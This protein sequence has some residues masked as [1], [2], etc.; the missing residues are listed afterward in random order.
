MRLYNPGN[1]LSQYKPCKGAGGVID[2]FPETVNPELTPAEQPVPALAE[3]SC[4]DTSVTSAETLACALIPKSEKLPLPSIVRKIASPR[5]TLVLAA[6]PPPTFPPN[7]K[8]PP[9]PTVSVD[10]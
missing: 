9:I 2:A 4:C 8:V 1:Y 6:K 3:I 10:C 5:S 7:S